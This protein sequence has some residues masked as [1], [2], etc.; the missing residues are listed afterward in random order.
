VRTAE[1]APRTMF[2][3]DDGAAYWAEQQERE[4]SRTARRPERSERDEG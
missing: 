4:A 2:H 1:G 3:P